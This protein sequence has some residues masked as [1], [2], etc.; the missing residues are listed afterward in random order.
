M[1]EFTFSI[2]SHGH[3]ALLHALL[4][5]L[6]NQPE[7]LGSSV[8][9]TLNV[10]EALSVKRWD[11]LNI[12]VLHNERPKGFGA[13]HNAAFEKCSTRWFV[14]LNPDLRLVSEETFTNLMRVAAGI[15]NLGAIAPTIVNPSGLIED[16][17]RC[18]LTPISL[19]RRIIFADRSFITP[20]QPAAVG[21]PFYWLAGMCI[22][23]NSAA[24]RAVGGFDE[25]FFLYGEDYDISARLYDAGYK[26]A[27]DQNVVV[28]HDAQRDSHRSLMHLR[29]H[30]ES[31]LRIWL[32]KIFW[33]VT[34]GGPFSFSA[35][36]NRKN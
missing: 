35:T 30:V 28:C 18:N 36:K 29:R 25:R 22:M 20:R 7:M 14:I 33:R 26:L 19:F 6:N 2:V 31:L 1:N 9:I 27:V 5:D 16:S 12:T 4:N 11:R 17:V 34:F 21:A 23:F 24:Y 10:H 8:I 13:N 15:Q 3:G 32:S